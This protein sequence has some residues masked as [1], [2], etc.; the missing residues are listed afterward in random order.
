MAETRQGRITLAAIL[1]VLQDDDRAFIVRRTGPHEYVAL[2]EGKV[3]EL[4]SSQFVE[5]FGGSVVEEFWLE[6]WA[7]PGGRHKAEDFKS[8]LVI[9][10]DGK[11]AY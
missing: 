1:A 8:N 7:R 6:N 11:G 10:S 5:M 2:T 4:R 9:V 3:Q